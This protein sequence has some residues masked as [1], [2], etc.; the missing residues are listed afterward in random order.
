MT[1]DSYYDDLVAVKNTIK[2]FEKDSLYLKNSLDIYLKLCSS[3]EVFTNI[4][5]SSVGVDKIEFQSAYKDLENTYIIFEYKTKDYDSKCNSIAIQ[6]NK[7]QKAYNI[8]F[9]KEF[10]LLSNAILLGNSSI[11]AP[12][13]VSTVNSL[14]KQSKR[15]VFTLNSEEEELLS[16]VEETIGVLQ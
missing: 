3:C 2:R 13:V 11:L 5:Y 14:Y 1:N 12:G 10:G 6:R 16:I 8:L 15:I 7:V 9:N 4:L